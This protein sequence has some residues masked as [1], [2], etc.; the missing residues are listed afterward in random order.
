MSAEIVAIARFFPK[1]EAYDR[2]LAALERVTIATHAEPGCIL[3]AL[4]TGDDGDLMQIGK[5]ESLDTWR[6]HGDAESVRDLD[7]DIE[8][9]LAKDREISWWHPRPVGDAGKNAV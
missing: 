2:V 7:R 9:L 6:A 4:H 3:V 8:G 1:P 5:W